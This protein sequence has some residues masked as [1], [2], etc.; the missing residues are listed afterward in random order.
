MA[1]PRINGE[2]QHKIAEL[3]EQGQKPRSITRNLAEWARSKEWADPPSE[4]SVRRIY[5]EHLAK[6]PGQRG[7]YAGFRWPESMEYAG[8]PWEA[9]KSVLN[10]L[11]RHREIFGNGDGLGPPVGFVR[12]FWRVEVAAPELGLDSQARIAAFLFL[13]E[14]KP[15]SIPDAKVRRLET[16]LIDEEWI[17]QPEYLPPDVL[18][19]GYPRWIVEEDDFSDLDKSSPA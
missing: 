7:Q 12:W 6:N 4:R 2:Y 17:N 8:I 9:S 5:Q 16:F 10:L 14:H 11:Q 19:Y 15:D 13:H 1:R 3:T 18:L